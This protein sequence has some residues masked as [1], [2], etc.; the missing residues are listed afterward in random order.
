MGE[1][2]SSIEACKKLVK[3]SLEN[4]RLPYITISPTFS[5]CPEHGY[6][7]GEHEFCPRCDENLITAKAKEEKSHEQSS[8]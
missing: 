4:F 5:I 3:R 1:Q 2:I 8:H 7:K 6:I